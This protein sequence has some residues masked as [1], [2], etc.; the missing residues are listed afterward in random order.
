L[1]S[2]PVTSPQRPGSC[3]IE[4]AAVQEKQKQICH[5]A[6]FHRVTLKNPQILLL[7]E[8]TDFLKEKKKNVSAKRGNA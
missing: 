4:W 2:Q 8:N 6:I 3:H 5:R 1:L 7:L